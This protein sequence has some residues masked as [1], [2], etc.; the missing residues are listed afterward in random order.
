VSLNEFIKVVYDDAFHILNQVKSEINIDNLLISLKK[1]KSQLPSQF[2]ATIASLNDF[3]GFLNDKDYLSYNFAEFESW[4]G[5]GQ[6]YVS[7][8]KIK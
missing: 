3:I 4:W 6:Q 7:L 8:R 2:N 1:L 5:R